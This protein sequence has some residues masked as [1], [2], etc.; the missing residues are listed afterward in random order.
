LVTFPAKW[1]GYGPPVVYQSLFENP[2]SNLEKLFL[3][4]FSLSL[5]LAGS[6]ARITRSTMLEVMGQDYIRTARAKGLSERIV[7]S[8]HALKNAMLPVIT[9]LGLQLGTL[10]GGTIILE[11]I[12]ALPG[13]GT[14]LLSSVTLKDYP[15]IQGIVLFFAIVVVM[16]NLLVDLSYGWFDPRVRYS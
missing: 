5:V 3:P 1:W 11:S 8:R 12:Y 13:L 7:L 6:L 10:L 16:L 14:L 2:L 4:S 9:L 15:Q